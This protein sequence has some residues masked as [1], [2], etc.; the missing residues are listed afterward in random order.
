MMSN[1][2][3]FSAPKAH[4]MRVSPLN[5]ERHARPEG[6]G[7]RSDHGIAE[8]EQPD[9]GQDRAAEHGGQKASGLD[10]EERPTRS[11]KP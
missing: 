8:D 3:P 4:A 10:P 7:D 9:H 6:E 5:E 1:R 2:R 11:T